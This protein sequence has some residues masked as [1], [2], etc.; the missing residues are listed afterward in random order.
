MES[1]QYQG[2]FHLVAG[3]SIFVL[4]LFFFRCLSARA[5]V[6]EKFD[7][8]D[9]WKGKEQLEIVE[10]LAETHDVKSVK[11]RRLEGKP[12]PKFLAGQFL[13]FQIG[14]NEKSVRSYSIS[15]SAEQRQTLRV[16]VKKI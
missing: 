8:A 16:S 15:S 5:E 9:I 3:F 14:E 7:S 4:T 10:V 13:S 1:M 11:L 2:F 12:F 6:K